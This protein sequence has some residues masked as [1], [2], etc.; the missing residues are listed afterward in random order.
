MLPLV[1]SSVT[2]ITP[3]TYQLIV[4]LVSSVAVAVRLK[5]A[6]APFLTD[7]GLTTFVRLMPT[8]PPAPTKNGV[9][10]TISIPFFVRCISPVVLST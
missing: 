4:I 6:F 10:P 7:E 9:N 5:M 1:F 2:L 3:F 8:P